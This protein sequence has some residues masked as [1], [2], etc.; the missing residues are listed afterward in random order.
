MAHGLE[1]RKSPR[2]LVAAALAYTLVTLAGAA[3]AEDIRESWGEAMAQG[4][5]YC[6]SIRAATLV[7]KE[8][9]CHNYWRGMYRR[10]TRPVEAIRETEFAYRMAVA[11][12][13]DRGTLSIEDARFLVARF[14][15]D[16]ENEWRR[17]QSEAHQ[18]QIEERRLELAERQAEA[19]EAR[20]RHIEARELE[21]A[22]RQTEAAERQAEAALI[23]GF[24]SWYSTWMNGLGRIHREPIRCVGDRQSITCF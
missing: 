6:R 2:R 9:Q 7:E 12:R 18:R 3:L 5:T 19:A 24:G 16:I 8:R 21:V 14:R 23:A 20:Q 22:E 17:R 11:A 1:L 10:F 4:N 13:V 15:Q